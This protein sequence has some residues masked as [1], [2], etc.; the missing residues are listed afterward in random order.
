M[1][2]SY[3]A[4]Q[5]PMRAS[6]PDLELGVPKVRKFVVSFTKQDNTHL[7]AVRA[8]TLRLS[9]YFVRADHGRRKE[10]CS[11]QATTRVHG[12]CPGEHRV[13][14]IHLNRWRETR[15]ALPK[16][17]ELPVQAKSNLRSISLAGVRR[18]PGLHRSS[19]IPRL[20]LHAPAVV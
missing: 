9:S 12:N 8:Q 5:S 4:N 13:Y 16:I 10:V 18:V 17:A 20:Q 15:P 3:G 14:V 11:L 19:G 6:I 1:R 2:K 7:D